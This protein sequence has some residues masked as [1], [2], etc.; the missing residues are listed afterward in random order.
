MEVN[1]LLIFEQKERTGTE[2]RHR[3]LE[4]TRVFGSRRTNIGRRDYALSPRG[5]T[6]ITRGVCGQEQVLLHRSRDRAFCDIQ[7]KV[8]CHQETRHSL[9]FVVVLY[10]DLNSSRGTTSTGPDRRKVEESEE[11][12]PRYSLVDGGGTRSTWMGN[13]ESQGQDLDV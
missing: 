3:S 5:E 12:S 4:S 2:E 7:G 11:G 13:V 9:R 10:P 8:R 6:P 1:G